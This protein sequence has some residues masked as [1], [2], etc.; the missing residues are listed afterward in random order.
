MNRLRHSIEKQ[1][2]KSWEA[3]AGKPYVKPKKLSPG[4]I[5]DT[6]NEAQNLLY[7][8]FRSTITRWL[9][10]YYLRKTARREL[11]YPQSL[12]E[13]CLETLSG[14]VRPPNPKHPT[15]RAAH[16]QDRSNALYYR[17]RCHALRQAMYRHGPS[18]AHSVRRGPHNPLLRD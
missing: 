16:E 12:G 13:L 18:V 10:D 9:S 11:T 17:L 8:L 7:S 1:Y 6:V 4:T 2:I 15:A 3:F 5:R 14:R